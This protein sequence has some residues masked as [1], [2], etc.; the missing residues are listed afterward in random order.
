MTRGVNK[1]MPTVGRDAIYPK[2]D[3]C[4]QTFQKSLVLNTTLWHV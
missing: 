4:G 2:E 3:Y 1:Y